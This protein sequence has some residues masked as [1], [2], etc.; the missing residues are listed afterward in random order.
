M[1]KTRRL[2]SPRRFGFPPRRKVRTDI[3]MI[4]SGAWNKAGRKRFRH[5]SG[6]EVFAKENLW[7]IKG[8]RHDGL[9]YET[10]WAA[11][12]IVEKALK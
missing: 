10:L 3:E 12:D 8:G 9:R 6:V 2:V 7:H 5:A 11:R 4:N 1:A